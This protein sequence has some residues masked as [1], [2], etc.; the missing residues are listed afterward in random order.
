D[1][2]KT[3]WVVFAD[4]AGWMTTPVSATVTLDTS[5]PS[6]PTVTL[7][8]GATATGERLVEVALSGYTPESGLEMR[9]AE[10]PSFTGAVWQPAASVFTHTL[11]AGD[12]AK[13]VYAQLR[14]AA[15]NSSGVGSDGI[16]IDTTPP[17]GATLA[18]VGNPSAIS[19]T[20]VSLTLAATGASTVDLA[21]NLAFTGASTFAYT[22][23]T[24]ATLSAGDGVKNLYARFCDDA[25]NCSGAV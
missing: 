2:V 22:T 19:S 4:Q 1:G 3:I 18:I 14:D 9:I 7:A 17:S 15:G 6:T 12:G 8:G 25:G 5:A 24:S 10:N 21:N 13:T 16:S 11:S 20:T 23:A